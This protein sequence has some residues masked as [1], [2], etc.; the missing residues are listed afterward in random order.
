MKDTEKI[1]DQALD[2]LR[3]RTIDGYE[4]FLEESSHFEVES[5]EGKVDTLQASRPWGMALRIL[6]R[7]RTGFSYTTSPSVSSSGSI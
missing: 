4:I 6:N 2:L 1:V 7:G 3:K 5:K